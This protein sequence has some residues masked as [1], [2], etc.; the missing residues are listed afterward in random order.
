MNF[1][2]NLVYLEAEFYLYV[3]TG[4]VMSASDSLSD[5]RSTKFSTNIAA[6]AFGTLLQLR[7]RRASM[8]YSF[9]RRSQGP[10]VYCQPTRGRQNRRGRGT[11]GWG[12]TPRDNYR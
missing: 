2:L 12:L 8:V 3:A 9:R 5:A 10:A 1:A 11:T 7:W 4:K 6:V